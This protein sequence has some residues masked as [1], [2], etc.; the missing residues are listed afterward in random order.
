MASAAASEP[1][2]AAAIRKPKP[3][4]PE[5]HAGRRDEPEN[6][7]RQ[8]DRGGLAHVAQAFGELAGD[9][10][11]RPLE[12]AAWAA[13]ECTGIDRQ[14]RAD[15]GQVAHPVENEGGRQVDERDEQ[16]GDR[17][18][19]D[20]RPV[21][22]RRIEGHRIGDVGTADHLDDERLAGGHLERVGDAQ[23]GGQD[24]DHPDL[25]EPGLDE[26]RE[27][28]R[29]DAHRRL[30]SDEDPALGERVREHAPEQAEQ[31]HRGV[32]G[33]CD[34]AKRER[35]IGELQDEPGLRDRG[36][37]RPDQGDE[38]AGP[39]EPEV[40]MAERRDPARQPARRSPRRRQVGRLSEPVLVRPAA[41]GHAASVRWRAAM[42]I[43][44]AA[45]SR[46]RRPVSR[47]RW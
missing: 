30:K 26:G 41:C 46:P 33:G 25:H 4:A 11:D 20:A 39:E 34:D 47:T 14:E 12:L 38:L 29:D 3:S 37:P 31:Q 40:A 22:G 32:L 18:T 35:V 13:M 6:A 45:V 15:G 21:E 44:S 1:T 24:D 27:S 43:S 5:V 42:T 23:G 8:E 10:P 19:D 7:E 2:P 16:S 36:H 9:R 17:R 28:E